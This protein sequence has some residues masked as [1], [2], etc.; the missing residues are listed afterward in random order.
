MAGAAEKVHAVALDE[1][2]LAAVAGAIHQRMGQCGGFMYHLSEAEARAALKPRRMASMPRS[3]TIS[4]RELLEPMLANM[5]E[6]NIE[7]TIL[8]LTAF[9]NRYYS[10]RSGVD[11]AN[12]LLAKWRDMSA[13]REDILV[14]QLAHQAY[15]PAIRQ[16]DHRR[17]RFA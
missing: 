1:S 17:H 11:A 13:G 15:P 12:W 9:P 6:K 5:Q 10:S 3:Y 4:H 8:A 14:A 16:L 2:R 7:S